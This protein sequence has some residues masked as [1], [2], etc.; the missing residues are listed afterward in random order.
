[1]V[2]TKTNAW[3]KKTV[4]IHSSNTLYTAKFNE[5]PVLDLL[6]QEYPASGKEVCNGGVAC[7]LLKLN[8]GWQ[9]T[10][11]IT[12]FLS[13][14]SFICSITN[15][16]ID[17]CNGENWL[18][19]L[20]CEVATSTIQVTFTLQPNFGLSRSSKHISNIFSSPKR[21]F[22]MMPKKI[23]FATVIYHIVMMKITQVMGKKFHVEWQK[24]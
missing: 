3:S 4:T 24:N 16:Y 7:S 11:S 13:L 21:V 20:D 23:L 17:I 10:P 2:G 15:T 6:V 18:L 5:F 9:A 19:G 14:R 12:K 1:M 8:G 22:F